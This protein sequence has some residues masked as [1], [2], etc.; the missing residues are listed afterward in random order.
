MSIRLRLQD[1]PSLPDHLL[2][3]VERAV[4]KL[5]GVESVQVNL[6]TE[7]AT[8]SYE[9][10]KVKMYEIKNAIEKAGFKVL[11]IEKKQSVD[12]DKLRKEKEL[13]SIQKMHWMYLGGKGIKKNVTYTEFLDRQ[14]RK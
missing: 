11:E 10:G 2:K 5:D 13:S 4:K 12:E 14:K 8:I 1:E 9:V 6:A 3:S 7:K